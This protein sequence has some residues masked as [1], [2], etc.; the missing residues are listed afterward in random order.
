[1]VPGY[2]K[3]ELIMG[4]SL[5]IKIFAKYIVKEKRFKIA[6]ML[7]LL[8]CV[9]LTANAI[10]LGWRELVK[11]T[12]WDQ[13]TRH[14]MF[15]LFLL[16]WSIS[17]LVYL[18]IVYSVWCGKSFG[19]WLYLIIIAVSL[20]TDISWLTRFMEVRIFST[21]LVAVAFLLKIASSYL[22]VRS[23]FEKAS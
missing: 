15:L 20:P 6:A 5:N 22:L 23:M 14:N 3:V 12:T 2:S 7:G 13:E 18:W 8:V 21:A 11:N 17:S 19:F 16:I 4:V 10:C 9:L 1:M